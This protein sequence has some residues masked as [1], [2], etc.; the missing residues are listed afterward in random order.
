MHVSNEHPGLTPVFGEACPPHGLSGLLRDYAYQFGEATNRHWLTLMLADRIDIVESMVVDALRGRPD[1]YLHEKQWGR[2]AEH[3]D[4]RT[5]TLMVV[6][7]AAL[8]AVALGVMLNRRS[9]RD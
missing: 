3:V 1:N 5:R 9:S 2:K 4:A 8:G 6:G 7:A